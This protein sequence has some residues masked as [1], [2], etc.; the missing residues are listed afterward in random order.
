MTTAE[1]RQVRDV[2]MAVLRARHALSGPSEQLWQ[3]VVEV[4]ETPDEASVAEGWER[5]AAQARAYIAPP[6]RTKKAAARG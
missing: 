5:L 1:G 6:P 3:Y 2:A 4:A